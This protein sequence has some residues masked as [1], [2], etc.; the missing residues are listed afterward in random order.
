MAV[1]GKE[2][3]PAMKAVTWLIITQGLAA[4]SLFPWLIMA[5]LSMLAFDSGYGLS[6][7][8]FIVL[9][10]LYPLLPLGCAIWAW[11]LYRHG[12]VRGA[13][14]TTSIPLVVA[15]PLVLYGARALLAYA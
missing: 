4:L 11:R 1:L 14:I 7:V 5:G 13:L 15:L 8:L 10:W 12:K 2:E 3:E 9:M 6:A